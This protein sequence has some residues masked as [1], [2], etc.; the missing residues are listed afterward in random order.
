[1]NAGEM[2]YQPSSKE[3]RQL[4][5]KKQKEDFKNRLRARKEAQVHRQRLV[6]FGV[7]SGL[8]VAMAAGFTLLR[9]L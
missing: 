9:H 3:R 7:A 1:M 8:F 4:R 6:V 5:T 2:T